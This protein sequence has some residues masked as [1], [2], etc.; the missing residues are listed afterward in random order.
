MQ[1]LQTASSLQTN[2]LHTSRHT[3][4]GLFSTFTNMYVCMSGCF[5]VCL[6]VVLSLLAMLIGSTLIFD[7]LLLLLLL[8]LGPTFGC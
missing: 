6:Q 5:L 4:I 8:L 2:S 7:L 1:Y 3:I